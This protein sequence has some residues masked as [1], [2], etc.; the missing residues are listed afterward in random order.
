MTLVLNLRQPLSGNNLKLG[1]AVLLALCI[2]ILGTTYIY[3]QQTQENNKVVYSVPIVIPNPG[4]PVYVGN[5]TNKSNQYNIALLLPFNVMQSMDVDS[6]GATHYDFTPETSLAIQYYHGALLALDSLKKTGIKLNVYALD[7]GSDS[8]TLRKIFRSGIIDSMNIIL[9]PVYNS[10]LRVAASLAKQKHKLLI[11]PFSASEYIT[12]QNS[13]YI[14]A[15]PTLSRHCYEMLSYLHNNYSIRKIT[16]LYTANSSDSNTVRILKNQAANFP[17]LQFVSFTDTV[18]SNLKKTLSATDTNLII[19]PSMNEDYVGIITKQLYDY[20]ATYPLV[21][22]GMPTWGDF[23]TVR[24]DYLTAIHCMI[25]GALW[26]NKTSTTY[27]NFEQ[28][29]INTYHTRPLER[30][31]TG[32]DQMMLAVKLLTADTSSNTG[33][34]VLSLS[35]KGLGQNFNFTPYYSIYNHSGDPDFIE[36]SNVHVFQFKDNSLIRRF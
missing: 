15:N 29:F 4:E 20:S 13:Y 5:P 16:L 9:G 24:L 32:Y 34:H 18:Y 25:T 1:S 7:G 6:S 28:A 8:N 27:L 2:S 19:V 26:C 30:N 12:R 22:F 21:V 31:I 3:A 11:S 36:N 35:Y 10:S 14:S 23:A 17:D 33:E